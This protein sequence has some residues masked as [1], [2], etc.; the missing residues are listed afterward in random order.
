MP[1][2]PSSALP[3]DQNF[4]NLIL[5]YPHDALRFFAAPEADLITPQARIIPLRQEQLKERLGE[6]FR[7]LDIPLMVEW[8]DGRR[9]AMVFAVEEETDPGRFDISRLAHYCLDLSELLKTR[10]VV[11]VVIFLRPGVYEEWLC[12]GSDRVNYLTFRFIPCDLGRIPAVAHIDSE[13]IV[14]RLNLPNMAHDRGQRIEVY[15]RA[16]EGLV[17]LERNLDRRIK[18]AEFI[19]MYA[20]LTDDEVVQYRASYLSGESRKEDVMGLVQVLRDEGER[21]MKKGEKKGKDTRKGFSKP[22]SWE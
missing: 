13:N 7:E 4:K 20:E 22:S 11:P 18:Y 8:P 17:T 19:D 1:T 15:A 5:D 12:L 3:H 14:A 2:Q 21:G 10:R 16:Q 6:R 9:A